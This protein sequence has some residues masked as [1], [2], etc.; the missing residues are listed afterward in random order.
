MDFSKKLITLTNILSRSKKINSFNSNNE[1]EQDT[2]AHSLLDIEES[3]KKIIDSLLP[4]LISDDLSEEEIENILFDI[5]E[6]LRHILYHI[7]TPKF[8]KYLKKQV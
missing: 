7:H 4:K 6:E 3:S 2:L 8:Y 1:K 5:G